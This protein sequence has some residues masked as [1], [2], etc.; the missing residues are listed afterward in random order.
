MGKPYPR[1]TRSG[2]GKSY[3]ILGR[4]RRKCV[5]S[6][7]YYLKPGPV[8]TLRSAWTRWARDALVA[9]PGVYMGRLDDGW[10]PTTWACNRRAINSS[11]F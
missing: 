3:S 1:P 4:T 6:F 2:H 9:L 5:W 7:T 10:V 8:V 11:F